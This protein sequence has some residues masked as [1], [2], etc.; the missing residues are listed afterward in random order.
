[1]LTSQAPVLA[2]DGPHLEVLS[3][4]QIADRRLM[5]IRFTTSLHDRL[6]IVIQTD[7]LQA[8]T[9]PFNEKFELAD[10][11]RWWLRFDG[12]PAEGLVIEFEFSPGGAIRL[13]LVEE[14]TGLPSFPGL[15]T[16]P[17]PGAMSSPGE[18]LQGVATDFTAIYRGYA[19][20][21]SDD[22]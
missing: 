1:M 5:S 14:K 21:G 15:V 17:P 16:Q 20:P 22:E 9:I 7:S 4:E 3:D 6:Y 12:M 10:N 19:L 2:L 8:I 18:F 11:N 13:L